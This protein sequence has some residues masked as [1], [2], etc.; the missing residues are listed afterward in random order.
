MLSACSRN[1]ASSEIIL[2]LPRQ[3]SKF[4]LVALF[5]SDSPS[6]VGA[7]IHS[8]VYTKA[9][10]SN[11][12]ADKVTSVVLIVCFF[13]EGELEAGNSG[14]TGSQYKSDYPGM[15]CFSFELPISLIMAL[16]NNFPAL[17]HKAQT[18]VFFRGCFRPK[19]FFRSLLHMLLVIFKGVRFLYKRLT[20]WNLNHLAK[21]CSGEI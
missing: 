2:T 13:N 10:P 6:T 20:F 15:A 21:F 8:R 3:P 19:S 5:L 14:G 1:S 12:K 7:L 16:W 17:L 4:T 11:G 18:F 9:L